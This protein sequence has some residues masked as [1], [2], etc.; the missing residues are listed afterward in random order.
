MN[1]TNSPSSKNTH[2]ASDQNLQEQQG[3]IDDLVSS[4]E[5]I[6]DFLEH[7]KQ[8]GSTDTSNLYVAVQESIQYLIV[9]VNNLEFLKQEIELIRPD[10]ALVKDAICKV[11]N[12][13]AGELDEIKAIL[14][15]MQ[16]EQLEIQESILI[17]RKFS[18]AQKRSQNDDSNWKYLSVMGVGIGLITAFASGL[19]VSIVTAKSAEISD[20]TYGA[21]QNIQN[22]LGVK[23][24]NIPKAKKSQ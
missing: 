23:T 22:H 10:I 9:V 24:K 18:S 14:E 20:A 21:I 16:K 2:N 3:Q 5:Q 4:L 8:Q 7:Q 11:S 12:G 17:V 13:R 19:S 6:F 15:S 1:R